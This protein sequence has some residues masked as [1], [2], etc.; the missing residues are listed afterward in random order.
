MSD[1]KKDDVGEKEESGF[2]DLGAL[3]PH[4]KS[5][6]SKPIWGGK[7]QLEE[8]MSLYKV[9]DLP[10]P[11]VLYFNMFPVENREHKKQPVLRLSTRKP[12]PVD[13]EVG[14][15]PTGLESDGNDG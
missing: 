9:A 3:W 11:A 5:T 10:L 15:V 8:I 12:E 2:V 14:D 4:E 13:D 1:V 7:F 6:K